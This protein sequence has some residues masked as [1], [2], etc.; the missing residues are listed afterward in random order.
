MGAHVIVWQDC[1]YEPHKSNRLLHICLPDWYYDSNERLPV[2]YFFDGHN[3]FFDEHAT[4]GRSWRLERFL[5]RWEKPMIVVGMECS[6][7]GNERLSEYNPYDRRLFGRHAEGLGEETMQ[8]V[9]RDVK[10]AID[11]QFRTWGHRE[12][13]GIAGSSMG[14][15]MSL[16]GVICHNET[17]GKAAALSG[18]IRFSRRDLL[19]DLTTATVSSDTR[20]FISWGERE[21]GRLYSH[22]GEPGDPA[23]DSAEARATHIIGDRLCERGA[24]VMTHYQPGGRHR[25]ADWE[26]QLPRL[27]DFLWLDR[28]W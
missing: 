5:A 27:M 8:W 9:I 19:R 6:H 4:Y 22:D 25:E 17:F 24:A 12:A 18:G 10:P 3:L 16:Y 2:M 11:Q 15:L 23:W 28:S 1:W 13:T 20:V 7:K 14:G 26:R 21:A